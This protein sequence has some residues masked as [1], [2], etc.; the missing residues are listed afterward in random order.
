MASPSRRILHVIP[1]VAARYGGPSAA[2]LGMCR[3]LARVSVEP[4][5]A[6]TDA[7]GAG[8][9]DVPLGRRQAYDGV[10]AIFFKRQVSEAFKW[11]GP[12]ATWLRGHVADFDAV[13]IHAVFSHSSV[14]AGRACRLAG[15][16]YVV[17]P[18]GTLDP[19]SVGQKAWRK[20]LLSALGARD[21]LTGAAAMHY[22]TA[23]EGRLAERS[24]GPLPD[25]V[26]IPVGLDDACFRPAAPAGPDGPYLLAL[27]RIDPKKRLDLAIEAFQAAAL[28]PGLVAWRFVI[29][30]DGH[31]DELARLRQVA[32]RG[33]AADRITFTGW[34]DGDT[35]RTLVSG[36]SLFVIP[37]HQE[38]FGVAMVEAMAAGVPVL[39]APGVNLA[40][41]IAAAGA[42][43]EVAGDVG[44]WATALREALNDPADRARRGAAA[45]QLAER[46]RWPAVAT[47]LAALYDRLAA[48]STVA[49]SGRAARRLADAGAE[50]R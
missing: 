14:A 9:L 13:H 48:M 25:G 26:V 39:A 49:R 44:P 5:I 22:T 41:E 10:P 15:V 47:A 32:A 8:R 17:R 34:V 31:P 12:L 11:S 38:N 19:W 37:S 29:A 7:D 1:A 33:P 46:F 4:L 36:A 3:A 20:R 24:S 16:P 43:W 21:L 42:G 18:L 6:T 28:T 45:R 23:E 50:G 40:R 2:V 30:G 35:K 27:S